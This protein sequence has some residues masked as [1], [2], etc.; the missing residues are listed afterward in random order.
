MNVPLL[1]DNVLPKF[2]LSNDSSD[3]TNVNGQNCIPYQTPFEY[4]MYTSLK[5]N[6]PVMPINIM[7]D[8]SSQIMSTILPNKYVIFYANKSNKIFCSY[9][10]KNV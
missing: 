3:M 7:P 9:N 1:P 8:V 5:Q 6:I 10:I 4:F 2:G